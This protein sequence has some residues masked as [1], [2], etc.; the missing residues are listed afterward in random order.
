MR[1]VW[2]GDVGC[3]SVFASKPAPTGWSVV[4]AESMDTRSHRGL[5]VDA[6]FAD[7]VSRC[8]EIT[9]E[10]STMPVLPVNSNFTLPRDEK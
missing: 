6:E 8:L 10:I 2:A 4:D 9:L 7:Q 1:S 5:A 3:A